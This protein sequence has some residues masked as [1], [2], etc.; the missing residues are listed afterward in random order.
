[1]IN[2]PTVGHINSNYNIKLD[3]ILKKEHIKI[4][5]MSKNKQKDF[6]PSNKMSLFHAQRS[7]EILDIIYNKE[8]GK[9]KARKTLQS[10]KSPPFT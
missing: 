3:V 5:K 9:Q 2:M 7:N 10:I 1:M 8:K 4:K 6:T